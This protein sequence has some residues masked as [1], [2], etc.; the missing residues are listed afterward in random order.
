MSGTSRDLMEI[1]R[2]SGAIE[3]VDSLEGETI[4]LV[5][6]ET[7][8]IVVGDAL[9]LKAKEEIC[10]RRTVHVMWSDV[11]PIMQE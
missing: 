1:N 5:Q 7:S 9:F 4:P 11:A 10:I 8:G 2:D 6:P 3:E